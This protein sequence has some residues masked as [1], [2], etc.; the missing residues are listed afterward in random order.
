MYDIGKASDHQS[1]IRSQVLGE[2][3]VIC[4]FSTVQGV[5]VPNSQVVG[6]VNCNSISQLPSEIRT[7]IITIL[8]I[9]K[10]G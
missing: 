6:W 9:K 4:G 7:I 5:G 10:L 2:P 3:K 8:Y 1:A